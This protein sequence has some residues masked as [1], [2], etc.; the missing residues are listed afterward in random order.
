M[1]QLLDPIERRI[2]QTLEQNRGTTGSD[3]SMDPIPGL[4]AV[5]TP[6]AIVAGQNYRVTVD[7]HLINFTAITNDTFADFAISFVAQLTGLS[8]FSSI[9][10]GAAS[11]TCTSTVT[12]VWT[13]PI[14]VDV[15]GPV[16]FGADATARSIPAH[17]LR[18]SL[19]N[20]SLRDP[21]YQFG[22]FDRAYELEWLST[23]DEPDAPTNP[24]DGVSLRT[25]RL[26][27]NIGYAYGTGAA[28]E[29]STTGYEVTTTSVLHARKRAL[30]DAEDVYD[31][32]GFGPIVSGMLGNGL[33]WCGCARDG[34]TTIDDLGGGRLVSVTTY[35][36]LIE[37]TN[38][39]DYSP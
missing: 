11:I 9:A 29:V 39:T 34:A 7:G 35:R 3:G 18:R 4:V 25:L 26:S 36:I 17:R 38:A 5:L 27:L 8:L 6:D 16:A 14:R 21:A 31:A 13:L 23:S 28:N 19:H 22:A 33:S 24:F 32:L 12:R 15:M 2:V 1:T 20:A 37:K 10:T 30:S